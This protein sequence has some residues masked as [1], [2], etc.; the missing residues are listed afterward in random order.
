MQVLGPQCTLEQHRGSV[1]IPRLRPD[2]KGKTTLKPQA[3]PVRAEIHRGFLSCP[4]ACAQMARKRQTC[5]GMLGTCFVFLSF[6]L[7]CFLPFYLSFFISLFLFAVF[8]ATPPS[9]DSIKDKFWHGTP[10]LEQR[11]LRFRPW[12]W[13]RELRGLGV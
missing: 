3:R 4:T 5:R 6:F 13:L 9:I 11:S 1:M 10:G 8:F 2:C 12:P 7:A